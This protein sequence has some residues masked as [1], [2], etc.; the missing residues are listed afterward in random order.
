MWTYAIVD[1]FYAEKIFKPKNLWGLYSYGLTN[2]LMKELID[3]YENGFP[4]EIDRYLVKHIQPRG[5]SIGITPQ[6]FCC[7]DIF[8]DNMGGQQ[9]EMTKR[10]IDS[11]FASPEDYI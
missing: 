7:Q 4:M 2:E 5:A 10:S 9:I 11:R 6:L 8:S 1:E 3:V